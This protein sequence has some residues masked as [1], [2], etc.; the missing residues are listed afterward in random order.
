[1]SREPIQSTSLEQP[2]GASYIALPLRHH[3]MDFAGRSSEFRLRAGWPLTHYGPCGTTVYT[4]HDCNPFP[5][6]PSL[7]TFG[8]YQP[9]VG[10]AGMGGLAGNGG[11]EYPNPRPGSHGQPAAGLPQSAEN[12]FGFVVLEA[13]LQS[14]CTLLEA[15]RMVDELCVSD[16]EF[17]RSPAALW[18]L[19]QGP[20]ITN[21]R[22]HINNMLDYDVCESLLRNYGWMEGM[23]NPEDAWESDKPPLTLSEFLGPTREMRRS[24]TRET[25]VEFLSGLMT[26]TKDVLMRMG[27]DADDQR[28]RMRSAVADIEGSLDRVRV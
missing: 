28:D 19:M 1:M 12:A 24:M 26:S 6:P 18:H 5:V 22:T 9:I 16:G 8:P 21:I 2:S 25:L 20:Y 15:C 23:R 17:S 10:I 3:N 14:L 11:I 4:G 27:R 13:Q 7:P